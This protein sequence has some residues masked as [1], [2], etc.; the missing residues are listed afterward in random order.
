MNDENTIVP[1]E[2]PASYWVSRARKCRG[3]TRL[4]DAAPLLRQAY[5]QSGSD[6]VAL[7]L[8][9]A[10]CAME[11]YSA[12]RRVLAQV[13]TQNPRCA[14]AY[15]ILGVTA[16]AQRDEGLAEDAL[17]TSLTVGGDS[18]FADDAQDLL[19]NYD[20]HDAPSFL[21]G[22]RGETLYLQA[23]D[24]LRD[25]DVN[26]AA[27]KL[28]KAVSRSPHPQACALLGEIC[29]KTGKLNE[30]CTY[31]LRAARIQQDNVPCALLLCEALCALD[32]KQTACVLLSAVSGSC[33]TH[34]QMALLSEACC[35]AGHPEIA[36]DRLE[37]ALKLAPQSNDL[38]LILAAVRRFEGDMEGAQ[39]LLHTIL[40][41][42]PEDCDAVS[43]L[44]LLKVRPIPFERPRMD[45]GLSA[46]CARPAYLGD[47]A[48][49]RL[50]HGLTISTDGALSYSS[51]VKLVTHAWSRMNKLQRKTCD[52]SRLNLW[53]RAFYLYLMEKA[54]ETP[55]E[56]PPLYKG[57]RYRRQVQRMLKYLKKNEAW[58]EIK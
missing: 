14:E 47:A 6:D 36:K 1:F 7:E 21:R 43:A 53:P 34:A 29:L 11:C 4:S 22:A 38:M 45:D 46:L 44:K 10:Y 28:R 13:L 42:D 37:K 23:L 30:A 50:I 54:G 55:D 17:A 20:W 39:R 58:S 3:R 19:N 57:V 35:E 12:A 48:L 49:K 24:A 26:A 56:E 18:G 32:Q 51:I 31:L 8:A 41:R 15:Y 2:R 52:T 25:G 9:G 27:L 33:E 40:T 16:L 5:R